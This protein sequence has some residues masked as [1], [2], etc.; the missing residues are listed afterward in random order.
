[1]KFLIVNRLIRPE[2]DP[3]SSSETVRRDAE[4]IKALLEGGDIKR[5]WVLHAGGHACIMSA[6]NSEEVA[7]KL[8]ANSLCQ[9]GRTSVI[10]VTDALEF[11]NS[12]GNLIRT[13]QDQREV[14]KLTPIE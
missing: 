11:I 4:K 6:S 7:S 10:P 13:E 8:R 2:A 5:A 9:I 14:A 12:R 1:M 3:H